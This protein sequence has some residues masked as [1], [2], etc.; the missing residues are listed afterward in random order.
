MDF[1]IIEEIAAPLEVLTQEEIESLYENTLESNLGQDI[2]AVNYSACCYA[3][4]GVIWDLGT[5][6]GWA[7]GATYACTQGFSCTSAGYN[8]YMMCFGYFEYSNYTFGTYGSSCAYTYFRG[9]SGFHC[10]ALESN[11][12]TRK[13][14][15]MHCR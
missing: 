7:A 13:R 10:G 2:T 6:S 9:L 4:H 11:G 5:A 8:T 3:N 15:G 12:W 14:T 1:D